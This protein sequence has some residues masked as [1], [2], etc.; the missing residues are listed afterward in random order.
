MDTLLLDVSAWDLVLDADGNIAVASNPYSLAQDAASVIRTYLGEVY[1]DT[2]VG[3]PYLTQVFGRVP[4]LTLLK[5]ELE[6]AAETV[7]E[8]TKAT[9][10]LTST[11][12]RVVSGQVQITSAATGTT[13]SATFT[14]IDPQ[15]VG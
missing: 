11:E 14:V 12:G 5:A 10:F 2:T 15:G 3:I 7:P 4:S 9:V 13:S 1:F 8:V 6:A